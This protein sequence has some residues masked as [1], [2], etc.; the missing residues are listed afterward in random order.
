MAWTFWDL[1]KIENYTILVV[2]GDM[3]IE[4]VPEKYRTEVQARVDVWFTEQAK[5]QAQAESTEI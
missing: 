4:E 3:K 1:K 5:L 2:R